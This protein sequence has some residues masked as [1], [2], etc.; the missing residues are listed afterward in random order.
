M[1]QLAQALAELPFD[2]F[3]LR[4]RREQSLDL[5]IEELSLLSPE[6]RLSA[7]GVATHAA[8]RSFLEQP[9]NLTCQLAVRGRVEQILL[10]LR[11]LDGTKDE[12]GFSRVKDAGVIGG[13]VGR[14]RPDALF[15]RLAE[16]KLGDLLK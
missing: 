8:A 16:A 11:A 2:Q 12:L 14:P 7:R 9:L 3:V 4:A 6:V 10:R 1:D 5:R 15:L 13:T